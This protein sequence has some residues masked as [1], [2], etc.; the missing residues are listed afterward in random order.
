MWITGVE[1]IPGGAVASMVE[2]TIQHAV[3]RAE[4]GTNEEPKNVAHLPPPHFCTFRL[5]R[6]SNQ[7]MPVEPMPK[8]HPVRNNTPGSIRP[9]SRLGT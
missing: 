4:E 2:P 1:L 5:A 3:S 6:S 7:R 9:T 8:A